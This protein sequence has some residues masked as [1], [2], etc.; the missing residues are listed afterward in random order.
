MCITEDENKMGE[1]KFAEGFHFYKVVWLFVIG[2]FLG[3][4]LETVF[5][6]ITMGRWMSRS[7]VVYGPFSVVWGLGVVLLSAILH[8]F[9][10]N[11][12]LKIFFVGSLLGGVYEYICSV[13][14]ENVFGA[15]FWNYSKIPLNIDGRINLLFCFFWGM[16]AIVWV[17]WIYPLL[18][19]KIEQIPVR[20]GRVLTWCLAVFMVINMGL[21]SCALNRAY[22]RHLNIPAQSAMERF[23][24]R[25]YED[26]RI[27]E[28]YPL[29]KFVENQK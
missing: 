3:D 13:F 25:N 18:S 12:I 22:E 1:E 10:K 21:S 7:S 29:L 15:K 28:I 23:L 26:E 27:K 8:R 24:D 2:A 4:L 17:R 11:Q 20:L 9:R 5:C 16:I 19:E 6:R 14:A